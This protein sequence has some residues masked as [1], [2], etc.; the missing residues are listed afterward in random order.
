MKCKSKYMFSILLFS[1]LILF[2][3]CSKDSNSVFNVQTEV[4]YNIQGGLNLIVTHFF[5]QNNVPTFYNS[6][7]ENSGFTEAAIG[8]VLPNRATLNSRFGENLDFI[9]EVSVW[10]YDT[11]YENGTEIFYMEPVELGTKTEIRLFSNITEVGEW[12][13]EEQ[14]LIELRLTLR[15]FVA[16]NLDLRL[17][18]D[19]AVFEKE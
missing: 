15:Q 2:P 16:A 12:I 9:N 18:L 1:M 11:N 3:S 19:F 14:V 6:Y 10:V 8:D 17:N 5:V 4:D 7:L 13:K